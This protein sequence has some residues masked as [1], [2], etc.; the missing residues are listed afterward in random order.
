MPRLRN[1][2]TEDEI[3]T[4]VLPN[5]QTVATDALDADGKAIEVVHAAGEH[6]YWDEA[7]GRD[8]YLTA[9]EVASG[10]ETVS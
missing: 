10:W 2:E 6:L 9:A 5:A 3:D 8:A 7:A 4:T 1:K